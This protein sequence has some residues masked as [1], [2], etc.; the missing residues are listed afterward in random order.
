MKIIHYKSLNV[1]VKKIR[2]K[3]KNITSVRRAFKYTQLFKKTTKKKSLCISSAFHSGPFA[4]KPKNRLYQNKAIFNSCLSIFINK[5]QI[6]KYVRNCI[7]L[8]FN[9][10][11]G[12]KRIRKL[13]HILSDLNFL[14]HLVRE[15]NCNSNRIYIICFG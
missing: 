13:T 8:H 3:L 12:L 1:F 10:I 5:L 9:N 14:A 4:Q 6:T 7:Y 15:R 11:L 2:F